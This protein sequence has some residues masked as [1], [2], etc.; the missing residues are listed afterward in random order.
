[1]NLYLTRSREIF[2]RQ[3]WPLYLLQRFLLGYMYSSSRLRRILAEEAH[4]A[5]GWRVQDSPIDIMV[6]AKRVDDGMPWYFVKDQP[7]N[8]GRTGKLPLMD[9]VTASAVAPT[10]FHP[11]TVPERDPPRVTDRWVH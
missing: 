9:C 11:W 1:M 8:R 6:T 4:E 2:A 3:P 7:G 5:S 10:F